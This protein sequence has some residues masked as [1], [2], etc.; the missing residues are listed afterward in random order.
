MTEESLQGYDFGTIAALLAIAEH[1]VKRTRGGN[2]SK[3]P[4]KPLH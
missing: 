1:F 2:H 4:G 3:R